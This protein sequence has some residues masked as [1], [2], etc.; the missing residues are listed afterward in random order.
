MSVDT[1]PARTAHHSLGLT[2]QRSEIEIDRLPLEGEVPAWLEGTLVRNGPALF[3]TE[4]QAFNHWFDGLAMLHAFSFTGGRVSYRN[5]FVETPALEG[6]RGGEITRSQFATDPCR[7]IFRRFASAFQGGVDAANPNVNVMRFGER[8]LAMTETPIPVEFD[9]A[10]LETLGVVDPAERPPG[11][12]T[13]AHPHQDPVTGELVSYAAKLGRNTTY[14]VYAQKP[15]QRPRVIRS[16]PVKEPAYMH[17]FGITERH[18]ILTE[19][20]LVVNPLALATGMLRGRPFIENYEWQPERGTRIH[21]IDLRDGSLRGTYEA[22]PQFC[23]HHVNAFER[24]GELVMDLATYE[25]ARV[26]DDFYLD[27]ARGDLVLP[28]IELSRITIALDRGSVRQEKLATGFE[29]ARIDYRNRNG[30]EY[31]FAYGVHGTDAFID[32]LQKI[33]IETGSV[34]VWREDDCFPGEPVFV[35]APEQRAED[36]G[37]VLSVVLDGAKGRSFLLVQDAGS[38]EELARAEVPQHI[39]FGFHGQHFGGVGTQ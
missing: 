10:T 12:I 32:T 8:F 1:A 6:A 24:D 22:R 25:D 16:I 17:S 15:G 35:P 37:L 26:I 5:R 2:T 29:L 11:Q 9:P 13:I 34:S 19:W 28:D 14:N 18:A 31:R 3:E 21:V 7:S 4:G 36:D 39:P 20:P 33:D 23:F 30:H 38:F 27:R